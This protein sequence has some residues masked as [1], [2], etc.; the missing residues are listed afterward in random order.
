MSEHLRAELS[1]PLSKQLNDRVD[2]SFIPEAIEGK[3]LKVVANKLV[4][5]F[6]E[7]AVSGGSGEPK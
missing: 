4:D 6:I 3:M 7:S 2:C 5:Q 1:D